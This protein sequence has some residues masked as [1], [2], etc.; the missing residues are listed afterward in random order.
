MEVTN[1]NSNKNTDT[2]N[3]TNNEFINNNDILVNLPFDVLIYI[4][5]YLPVQYW[6]FFAIY[7]EDFAANVIY[8]R[9]R[10]IARFTTRV[11]KDKF[12]KYRVLGYLHRESMDSYNNTLPA[13]YKHVNLDDIMRPDRIFERNN[14]PLVLRPEARE[15]WYSE[16]KRHS[17]YNNIENIIDILSPKTE[18]R[19]RAF[20]INANLLRAQVGIDLFDVDKIVDA[21]MPRVG[22]QDLGDGIVYGVRTKS[23]CKQLVDLE[24]YRAGVRH[25]GLE[26]CN[27]RL[28]HMPAVIHA[29]GYMEWRICG[30]FERINTVSNDSLPVKMYPDG[31]CEY[32]IDNKFIVK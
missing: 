26:M 23:A 30:Q 20:L 1:F 10:F 32:Y 25:R 31:R 14:L 2:D 28:L 5:E 17:K 21:V 19:I 7:N 18:R 29:S 15:E 3:E 9:D 12:I 13:V 4:V 8:L 27:G 24:W 11:K 22:A 6:V 16:Y